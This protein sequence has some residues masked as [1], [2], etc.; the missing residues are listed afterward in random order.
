M[1]YIRT[2]IVIFFNFLS[3]VAGSSGDLTEDVCKKSTNY[4]L[5]VSFLRANPRSSSADKKGLVCIMIQLSLTKAKNIYNQTLIILKQPMEPILQQCL[6]IC[7]DNYDLAVSQITSSI[8]YLDE[9]N[10]DMVNDGISGATTFSVTYKE[11]FTEWHSVRK[12]PLKARSDDFFHFNDITL[13]LL[14]NF[15]MIVKSLSLAAPYKTM[16]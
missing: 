3:L 12:D 10:F 1:N 9:N 6:Q 11:S 4:K 5:C 7:R 14:D 15:Q 16:V 8:K 2:S 13:S